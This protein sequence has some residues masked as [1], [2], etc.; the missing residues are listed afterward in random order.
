MKNKIEVRKIGPQEAAALLQDAFE[1][2][3]KRRD[4][5]IQ[6]LAEDM[7]LGR[8]RLSPDAVL[9]CQG[10]LANGQHRLAAVVESGLTQ[11]FVVM[12]TN[13]SELYKV[14]DSG[15]GRTVGDAIGTREYVTAT[16]AIARLVCLYDKKLLTAY[17]GS[18][19]K[20]GRLD[21]I[22]FAQTNAEKI[23]GMIHFVQPLFEKSPIIT[24]SIMCAALMLG[25]RRYNGGKPQDFAASV[26]SGMEP[27]T[28]AWV[29]REKMIKNSQ[30]RM[31]KLNRI[32]VFALTVKS[33]KNYCEGNRVSQ[34]RLSKGEPFPEI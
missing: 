3:R 21:L 18:V 30:S 26:Y 33:L 1:G 29:L 17:G 5:H 10:K 22:E 2:Q 7:R 8:F 19:A 34:V 27:D 25:E 24:P 14:L 13:D 4:V 9:I 20:L 32:Y 15:I 16:S 11:P 23:N 6:R 28:A 31:H 12:E